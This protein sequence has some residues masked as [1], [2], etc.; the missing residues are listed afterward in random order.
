MRDLLSAYLDYSGYQRKPVQEQLQAPPRYKNGCQQLDDYLLAMICWSSAIYM[1]GH[2][3]S[4]RIFIFLSWDIDVTRQS[5]SPSS[6]F[7]SSSKT[8]NK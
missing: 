6:S 5:S 8:C 3:G 4:C 2:V 1:M 7:R